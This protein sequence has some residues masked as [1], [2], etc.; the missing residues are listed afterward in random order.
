MHPLK[1]IFDR[2]IWDRREKKKNYELVF[3]HRGAHKDRRTIP[4]ESIKEVSKST[5]TYICNGE[6][7]T[8]PLHRVILVRN[9]QT[10][11]FIWRKIEK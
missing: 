8:I 4:F 11:E 6:N 7:I 10:K 9:I 2:I 5:L 1:K 3:I